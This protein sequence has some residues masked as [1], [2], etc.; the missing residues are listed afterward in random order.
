MSVNGEAFWLH[1]HDTCVCGCGRIGHKSLGQGSCMIHGPQVCPAFNLALEAIAASGHEKTEKEV[2]FDAAH[3]IIN[4]QYK[5]QVENDIKADVAASNA[6]PSCDG[7]IVP[8]PTA[9]ADDALG[10]PPN[11]F[12]EKL[13]EDYMRVQS[14][15]AGPKESFSI[16]PRPIKSVEKKK[17]ERVSFNLENL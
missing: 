7:C 12:A 11:S 13:D 14:W 15:K 8:R 17:R 10:T 3:A 16:E 2:E 4:S 9:E 6:Y 1:L 5:K